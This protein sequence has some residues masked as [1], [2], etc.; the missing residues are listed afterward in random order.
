MPGNLLLFLPDRILK[1]YQAIYVLLTNDPDI[2]PG[3]T[4]IYIYM[5]INIHI[6]IYIYI[7]RQCFEWSAIPRTQVSCTRA[8]LIVLIEPHLY[9]LQNGGET[10]ITLH[11]LPHEI[12]DLAYHTTHVPPPPDRSAHICWDRCITAFMCVSQ[13]VCLCNM[14]LQHMPARASTCKWHLCITNTVVMMMM[15]HRASPLAWDQNRQPQMMGMIHGVVVHGTTARMMGMMICCARE[16][17]AIH[18]Y[19]Q[20]V[21]TA[22]QS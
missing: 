16:S 11:I 18:L 6:H 14:S 13:P 12:N 3:N 19:Q 17:G 9:Y 7:L 15:A 20:T 4:Y 8:S 1:S 22:A 2:I 5:Y 21:R 10:F